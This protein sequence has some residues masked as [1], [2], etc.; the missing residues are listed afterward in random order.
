MKRYQIKQQIQIC[1]DFTNFLCGRW[2]VQERI[3]TEKYS[4][5]ID[6]ISVTDPLEAEELASAASRVLVSNSFKKNVFSLGRICAVIN[7]LSKKYI[8]A[9]DAKKIFISH[10]SKDKDIIEIFIDKILRL[11]CSLESIDIFCTSIEDMGIKNGNDIRKHIQESMR[12]CDYVFLMISKNYVNSGMCLN[13]MGASWALDKK[14]KPFLFPGLDYSAIWLSAALRNSNLNESATL[15]SLR[16]ELNS[17]FEL[18]PRSTSDWNKQKNDFL[19]Y[20]NSCTN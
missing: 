8:D 20:L 18:K 17:E 9:C 5:L 14:V 2:N 6:V 7:I 10:S 15:D 16:D 11:G 3:S 13:E 4:N 12:S 19:D 1:A